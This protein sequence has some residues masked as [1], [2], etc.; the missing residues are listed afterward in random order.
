MSMRKESAQKQQ[1]ATKAHSRLN[2]FRNTAR[3]E[4]QATT[5]FPFKQHASSLCP[6]THPIKADEGSQRLMVVDERNPAQIS[7]ALTASLV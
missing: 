1:T 4:H 3:Q 7:E 2:P 5:K 6:E